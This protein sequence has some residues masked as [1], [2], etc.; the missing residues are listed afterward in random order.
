[1]KNIFNLFSSKSPQHDEPQQCAQPPPHRE[2]VELQIALSNFQQ[3]PTQDLFEIC[4]LKVVEIFLTRKDFPLSVDYSP[5][6]Q[7]LFEIIKINSEPQNFLEDFFVHNFLHLEFLAIL[8]NKVPSKFT[9]FQIKKLMEIV[10][11]V[12]HFV[13]D[14]PPPTPFL[15]QDK[16]FE[17][18]RFQ[19]DV[20]LVPVQIEKIEVTPQVQAISYLLTIVGPFCS[21]ETKNMLFTDELTFNTID[22]FIDH[23]YRYIPLLTF[24]SPSPLVKKA[25]LL[26]V[27]LTEIKTPEL[28]DKYTKSLLALI[29]CLTRMSPESPVDF[30]GLFP[31]LLQNNP[32]SE[33]FT[34]YFNI[35]HATQNFEFVVPMIYSLGKYITKATEQDYQV[36]LRKIHLYIHSL[37][38]TTHFFQD[39]LTVLTSVEDKNEWKNLVMAFT[40]IMVCLTA[41]EKRAYFE[42]IKKNSK[43][44]DIMG[45][46]VEG[47][48][49]LQL[50]RFYIQE[51]IL[52]SGVSYYLRQ[53]ASNC[54]GDM[55]KKVL[56]YL[57]D[58]MKD[59]DVLKYFKTSE[60]Q[61]FYS[62]L[63]RNAQDKE[64]FEM[65][66][67]VMMLLLLDEDKENVNKSMGYIKLFKMVD[68]ISESDFR[69]QKMKLYRINM[70]EANESILSD[71]IYFL[72]KC[73]TNEDESIEYFSTFFDVLSSLKENPNG[74][75]LFLE[76]LGLDEVYVLIK[77]I[78]TKKGEEVLYMLRN[79][80]LTKRFNLIDNIQT[81]ILLLKILLE[82]SDEMKDKMIGKMFIPM[83]VEY[84]NL[85]V[86]SKPEVT[87]LLLKFV[88]K[89][90]PSLHADFLIRAIVSYNC[91]NTVLNQII[92]KIHKER[93]FP[94]VLQSIVLASFENI[95]TPTYYLDVSQR[96]VL[97]L[98]M[99][100]P[101][102]NVK[103]FTVCTWFSIQKFPEYK[104]PTV[105]ILTVKSAK[106]MLSLHATPLGISLYF[107]NTGE[108]IQTSVR[109]KVYHSIIFTVVQQEKSERCTVSI[110]F[111]GR[112]IGSAEGNG[113]F[114]NLSEIEIKSTAD[115]RMRLGNIVVYR[116]VLSDLAV[117]KFVYRKDADI[118]PYS[119]EV[120]DSPIDIQE[121]KDTRLPLP[122]FTF[123]VSSLKLTTNKEI[124]SVQLLKGDGLVKCIEEKVVGRC[125]HGKQMMSN[126]GGSDVLLLLCGEMNDDNSVL[127]VIDVISGYLKKNGPASRY[128]LENGGMK[129]MFDIIES[130]SGVYS[131]I[132]I[133]ETLLGFGSEEDKDAYISKLL[134]EM[135]VLNIDIWKRVSDDVLSE[136]MKKILIS[137]KS[138]YKQMTIRAMEE[139]RVFERFLQY[140][141]RAVINK[142][143]RIGYVEVMAELLEGTSWRSNLHHLSTIVQNNN[144]TEPVIRC[145][146]YRDNDSELSTIPLS[147]GNVSVRDL[148]APYD[149]ST[150]SSE[151]DCQDAPN[152]ESLMVVITILLKRID[153]IKDQS[154]LYEFMLTSSTTVPLGIVLDLIGVIGKRY[155]CDVLKYLS[156]M[157]SIQQIH[158][159]FVLAGG[160]IRLFNSLRTVRRVP[161]MNNQMIMVLVD[162]IHHL[163]VLNH[164]KSCNVDL[165][166]DPSLLLLVACLKEIPTTV[167]KNVVKVFSDESIRLEGRNLLSSKMYSEVVFHAMLNCINRNDPVDILE[168]L[169]MMY[170]GSMNESQK[171]S[172]Q[173][174]AN[175]V[176]Q[177]YLYITSHLMFDTFDSGLVWRMYIFMADMHTKYVLTQGRKSQKLFFVNCLGRIWRE[178]ILQ[179]FPIPNEQKEVIID[180]LAVK[181]FIIEFEKRENLFEEMYNN[182]PVVIYYVPLLQILGLTTIFATEMGKKYQNNLKKEEEGLDYINQFVKEIYDRIEKKEYT[183]PYLIHVHPTAVA[184]E[185]QYSRP[186]T[187]VFRVKNGG[188]NIIS[189][190]HWRRIIKKYFAPLQI[191]QLN[192]PSIITAHKLESVISPSYI[193]S[194]VGYSSPK[195][196]NLPSSEGITSEIISEM[197]RYKSLFSV[198]KYIPPIFLTDGVK[199][200]RVR[201]DNERDGFLHI[202]DET[203]LVFQFSEQFEEEEVKKEVVIPLG[204]SI[205]TKMMY[206]YQ[207]TGLEIIQWDGRVEFFVFPPKQREKITEWIT[208]N[209]SKFGEVTKTWLKGGMS[210]FEYIGAINHEAGRSYRTLSQ[211]PIYPWVISSYDSADLR[212]SDTQNYR[213]LKMPIGAQKE[214]GILEDNYNEKECHYNCCLSS[215]S[216]VMRCL[217]RLRPFT[218]LIYKEMSG[219][220][221][222][223]EGRIFTNISSLYQSAMIQ[224]R[225]EII[226]EFYSTPEVFLD[227]N[228]L[229]SE[230]N[231]VGDVKFPQWGKTAREFVR[232]MREALES[233][234]VTMNLNE[235]IDLVFGVDQQNRQKYNVYSPEYTKDSDVDANL[236]EVIWKTMG[237]IPN[238][239]FL[240]SHPKR[241]VLQRL[242]FNF[243]NPHTAIVG[244][245]PKG[246]V[247]WVENGKFMSSAE[248][249]YSYTID[250]D[251][252]IV[253]FDRLKGTF[254]QLKGEQTLSS[255]YV[256]MLDVTSFV[257]SDNGNRLIYGS[258]SGM[259]KLVLNPFGGKRKV[260]EFNG[261]EGEVR[262]LDYCFDFH[263]TVIASND[264]K[265]RMYNDDGELRKLIEE[266]E[267]ATQIIFNQK[268]GD[269]FVVE[270]DKEI[271]KTF[272]KGFS[273][274]GECFASTIISA[275]ITIA[276]TT[277]FMDGFIKNV[278]VFGSTGGEIMLY[279]TDDL[280]FLGSCNAKVGDE[281]P[282]KVLSILFTENYS[283]LYFFVE[284][285]ERMVNVFEIK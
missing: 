128:F 260:I 85:D 240:K 159:K 154:E 173:H 92:K 113:V 136:Y 227:M 209:E 76:F 50:S 115:S 190:L 229:K 285:T 148:L 62:N 218:D 146:I 129:I 65:G 275:T 230:K 26:C 36:L 251:Q 124:S 143:V 34:Y 71:V 31:Y 19:N 126:I 160:Y 67:E 198:V 243:Y 220:C 188:T 257:V 138:A 40:S 30:P 157:L 149:V 24:N 228:K 231:E 42:F 282:S 246:V 4:V 234:E 224:S 55:K 56:R 133:V 264:C 90:N 130:K 59:S 83:T 226:P 110:F 258:E 2:E 247:Y 150:T 135:V 199:C 103:P 211:Y 152:V 178:V 32:S 213:N 64:E 191:L 158:N 168:G 69:I 70:G 248:R 86:L 120:I 10:V 52:D 68:G 273:I 250:K 169:F 200:K 172:V 39:E 45:A 109:E 266:K 104:V 51:F 105:P 221:L 119:E 99:K 94:E 75:K 95:P 44:L 166:S 177:H 175:K 186:P 223:I 57:V 144:I 12:I 43:D 222:E 179:E 53:L 272:V 88:M 238:K 239:V 153:K 145:S 171:R 165:A 134:V 15:T 217:F 100:L 72:K 116:N 219:R 142:T 101:F 58:L 284:C 156:V 23:Y 28:V 155:I 263:T 281:T 205:V 35:M 194:V 192:V 112:R 193:R 164:E 78:V 74:K 225:I 245:V 210:N 195:L 16:I 137:F 18:A 66:V 244:N 241:V 268:T 253:K 139:C 170:D 197:E 270:V 269:F 277:Q 278:L 214:T 216:V 93:N 242:P 184:N 60:P 3:L 203:N 17:V 87:D 262:C 185:V 81:I 33:S 280:T 215:P 204:N 252:F 96:T 151:T 189:S 122:V 207:D 61:S 54:E 162:M 161:T 13:L 236:R 20:L 196:R 141:D 79:I 37:Y 84:A 283:K 47:L 206:L 38:K 279:Q 25:K 107:K 41:D 106:S 49:Q 22:A 176:H 233:N 180:K 181:Q 21:K 102:I 27:E 29:L 187:R 212:L 249:C 80:A 77:N 255:F 48:S 73:F 201:E 98:N 259:C 11:H 117:E 118:L 9:A 63:M 91:N 111:D 97:E 82:L 140:F 202:V 232:H 267:M 147:F 14:F 131:N 127:R 261:I 8:T 114:G 265:I 1:M 89:E 6:I 7:H 163:F 167:L 274:N 235:W 5:V 108:L 254:V 183:H 46:V 256:D 237:N 123:Q 271:N 276:V 125:L 174:V 208:I 182:E 121:A 132:N